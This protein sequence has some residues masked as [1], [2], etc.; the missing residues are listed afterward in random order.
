M[1][2]ALREVLSLPA[3]TIDLQHRRA[4]EN[5]PFFS[6]YTQ[7]FYKETRKRHRRL[8][9]IRQ[10]AIGFAIHSL[11][12]A[13]DDY[14]MNIEAAARRNWKKANRN[15]FTF[16]LFNF[17]DHLPEI[18]QI[19]AS[20]EVRQGKMPDRLLQGDIKENQNPPSTAPGHDYPFYG[21]FDSDGTL[22]AYAGCF[23]CGEICMIETIYG[24]DDFQKLGVVPF[25]I[26]E[27]ARTLIEQYPEVSHYAYGT[28]YGASESLQR[29]KRKFGFL[30]KRVQWKLG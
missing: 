10:Y 4:L 9:L 17:N 29:F 26:I 19:V 13:F 3:L 24:H 21:V 5:A 14:F 18:R 11:P 30:P 12:K 2:S 27:I 8:P 1:L 15:D 7:E 20:A 23:L 6:R 25:L 28:Y 22:R 16:R